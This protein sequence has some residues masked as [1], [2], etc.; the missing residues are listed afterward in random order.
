MSF[1]PQIK[2]HGEDTFASNSLAFATHAEADVYAKQ[3]FQ[4]W[5]A[6]D[7]WRV[8]ESD[9]PVNCLMVNGQLEIL[10]VV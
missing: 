6:A 8:I 3:L 5:L 2:A 1:K 10:P 7:E 4:R 9:Q